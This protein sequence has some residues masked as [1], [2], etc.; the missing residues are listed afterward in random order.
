MSQQAVSRL[1]LIRPKRIYEQIA[2]QVEALIRKGVFAPGARLPG[3]RELADRLGVSRPSLREALIALETTGL[4]E[5][6]IG[7]GTYVRAEIPPVF[8]FPLGPAADLGPGTLEQ[9]EARQALECAC[10]ELA[11]ARADEAD[12][13]ALDASLDRMRTLAASG[14]SP[15]EEHRVF[16]V[17]LADSARNPILAG[18]VRELWRLRG[19]EMWEILRR[20]VENSQSW[21]A[22]IRFRER[23]MA[24]LRDRDGTAARAA[25][26]A[27]FR[28]V[29]RMYF[30]PKE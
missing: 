12:F 29:G 30:D 3:E 25:M 19:E 20:K 15:S 5:T 14:Q 11:A 4:I 13:G 24:A 22:G 23:L 1:K 18:A 6:R 27:H 17:R 7:D 8:V 10:A 2:E 16:H 28:R 26:R 9:F 21:A